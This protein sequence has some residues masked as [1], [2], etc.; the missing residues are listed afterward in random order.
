MCYTYTHTSYYGF[1]FYNLCD[2]INFNKSV[3]IASPYTY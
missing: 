1:I 2:G 3:L